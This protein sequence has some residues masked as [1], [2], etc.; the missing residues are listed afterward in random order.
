MWAERPW[1]VLLALLPGLW[2][3]F[4][5]PLAPIDETRVVG[6]AWEMWLNGDF[7]VPHMNGLPYS[8]KPPLLIWLINLGWAVFGVNEWWPRLVGPLDTLAA[9]LLTVKLAGELWPDR[10]IARPITGW[11]LAGSFGWMFYGQLLLYDTLLTTSVI[12]ALLGAWRAGSGPGRGGWL[13]VASGIGLGILSKGPVVLV[14]ILPVLLLGPAWARDARLR[15][16][17]WY[18]KVLLATVGGLLI[19][20]LWVIPAAV[21]GGEEYARAILLGQTSGRLVQSFAHARPWWAYLVFM[22]LLALPWL[23]LPSSWR[24]L[25]SGPVAG[26]RRFVL[27]W[28]LGSLFLLSLVS[29]KQ[30]HY[31][32]PA[33]P[34]VALLIAGAV[35]ARFTVKQVAARAIAMVLV[36]LT[37]ATA[38]F[39]YLD[40]AEKFD[41]G[42]PGALAAS[43]QAAGVPLATASGYKNQLAFAGRL[44]R[45]LELLEG[46]EFGE[47]L[48]QNPNGVL[49]SFAETLPDYPGLT[50]YK[51][52]PYR[53]REVRF[54]RL[55]SQAP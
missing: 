44:E 3:L 21:L 5:R 8:H 10:R 11:L 53:R 18:G 43:L 54:L 36:S 25:F 45:P 30:P 32:I 55:D 46:D 38:A 22:P 37:L 31:A 20:G 4:V 7:L 13:L 48:R 42:P 33:L 14:H 52:F 2:T 6:V 23:L 24:A 17:A 51:A 9:T 34:A 12:I 28:V 1:W 15:P 47:W 26:G 35:S 29:A 50:V 41:M 27:C 16:L 40:L 39:A 49:V 19:A